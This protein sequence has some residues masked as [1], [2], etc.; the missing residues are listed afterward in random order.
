MN[1]GAFIQKLFLKHQLLG[2]FLLSSVILY[3]QPVIHQH[4]Q[5]FAQ[6][7]EKQAAAIE[8]SYNASI[9]PFVNDVN[10]NK[11]EID[12]VYFERY[13]LKRYNKL[14]ARK[15]KQESL[16]LVDSSNFKLSVDP[17]FYFETGQDSKYSD[18][19][20]YTNTRG[21]LVKGSIGN[22]FAFES[23]FLENQAVMVDYISDFVKAWEVV[24][25]QGRVKK[26]KN[27]GYDFA[28]AS[29]V[30]SYSPFKYLNLMAGSGKLF[31]GNGYRSLLL[32]D[33]S[34]NYPYFKVNFHSKKFSYTATW[35]SMQVIKNGRFTFN[36]LSEPIFTKK[37]YTFQYLSYRPIK[38]VELCLF[39]AV[40]WKA[41][42]P[43]N[44][45]FDYDILNPVIFAH[46]AQ[47][48]LYDNN[49]VMLGANINLKITSSI[50]FYGQFML[51]DIN[52]GKTGFQAGAKYFDVL[53][54][55]NLY[56]Q[57]EYNK[58]NA[59]SYSLPQAYQS[60]SHYNQA[61]AHPMGA[62]FN[63]LVGIVNYRF[64]DFFISAKLN[65]INY[66]KDKFG[67]FAGNNI[68]RDYLNSDIQANTMQVKATTQI[69]DFK[70]GYLVNR[71]SNL[72]VSIGAIL[73]DHKSDFNPL[74]TNYVYLSIGTAISN[75]Y[76]D[77]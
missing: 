3:A 39:Q 26:F 42:Q 11:K 37:A 52:N 70:L 30:I 28:N 76:Y 64:K 41:Q 59:Y 45:Q 34:F 2:I 19:T 40:M 14:G 49:N 1:A 68:I 27:N 4:N 20:Y 60:F 16:L 55:K 10:F 75:K 48:N 21:V 8:N 13:N 24:P 61:I 71:A 32:S 15:L 67:Y 65:I 72:N 77:F 54:V 35:A 6:D 31:V 5:F 22:D 69:I 62:N 9:K 33:N 73:R 57:T 7:I 17:L 18:S 66:G 50:N 43:G 44:L 53:K 47:Y 63:E 46:A 38:R 25:G 58:V 12:S 51:D 23:T 29:G 56:M 74:Q 36:I